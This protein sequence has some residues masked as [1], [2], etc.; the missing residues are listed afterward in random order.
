MTTSKPKLMPRLPMITGVGCLFSLLMLALGGA[1]G[2]VGGW[3]GL[4]LLLNYAATENAQRAAETLAWGEIQRLGTAQAALSSLLD[5]T[6]FANS[7]NATTNALAVEGTQ[8][9]LNNQAL[10]LAQTATS[11][12]LRV[13]ATQTANVLQNAQQMTQAALAYSGTQAALAQNAT[14]AALCGTPNSAQSVLAPSATALPS[15]PPLPFD[16]T[17][18]PIQGVVLDDTFA[19]GIQPTIWESRGWQPGK[20]GLEAGENS[21]LTT[22]ATFGGTYRVEMTFTPALQTNAMYSFRFADLYN[23]QFVAE[24]LQV[25]TLV[26]RLDRPPVAS[27]IARIE[28]LNIPLTQDSIL[29]VDIQPN[30]VRVMLNG[31]TTLT[32]TFDRPLNAHPL[33]LLLPTGAILKQVRV[34]QG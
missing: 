18:T 21:Y 15:T 13:A 16:M 22:L 28:R 3:L 8:A 32:H 10:L 9:A 11:A 26:L 34:I 27:E 24:T 25:N 30:T 5:S 14:V 6:A 7:A 33:T 20:N 4:P 12:A 31:V 17:A 29:T 1:L 19:L 23:I 2:L